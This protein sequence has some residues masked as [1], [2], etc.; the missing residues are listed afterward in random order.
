MPGEAASTSGGSGPRP[1]SRHGRITVSCRMRP[2][3]DS[4]AGQGIARAPWVLTENS[5]ALHDRPVGRNASLESR[6]APGSGGSVSAKT[7]SELRAL[8]HL[9]R[10]DSEIVMDAVFGE[11]ATT[12]EVYDK[13]FKWIVGGTAEGLNG[14]ILAYGQTCSGKTYSISGASASRA[15]D[16]ETGTPAV[17]AAKGIIHF[18]LEDL[19]SSLEAKASGNS[20]CECLVRMSYCELYMERVNDLLRK[21]SPQ[22]QHLPVKEDAENRGTFYVEGL[23]E[24]IVSSSEEVISILATAEKRRR[25]AHTKYNE[26]SSRS[27]TLLTMCVECSAPL[28]EAEGAEALTGDEPRVTK[29]SRLILVDLAGNERVDAGTEYMAES[30]SINKSLF[31]LGKVIEKLSGRAR[32]ESEGGD[33]VEAARAEHV[34][35][36]DSKLTRL[37]SVHLGGNSQTGVLVTLTPVEDCIEQSLTTL[38][39]AQKAA[40]IRCVAKPTLVSKE[41][42]LIIKQR[43]IISQL[44]QQVR[45]LKEQQAQQPSA[46]HAPT[47]AT[48]A[49]DESDGG[50]SAERQQCVEHMQA[51]VV[52]TSSSSSAV[53]SQSREMDAIVTALHRNNDT[54]RKQKASILEEFRE[55][56]R[57]IVEVVREV[58]SSVAELAKTEKAWSAESIEDLIAAQPANRPSTS[59][60]SAWE[61]AVKD[62]R[63]QLKALLQ[64]AGSRLAAAQQEG[65]MASK[66]ASAVAFESA[67]QGE[68]LARKLRDA[69]DE[70]RTLQQ[71]N[72]R[73]REELAAAA[74]SRA[75]EAEAAMRQLREENSRLRTTMKFLAAER[76][77]PK[78][79]A[80]LE[81]AFKRSEASGGKSPSTLQRSALCFLSSDEVSGAPVQHMQT[82]TPSTRTS[83]RIRSGCGTR[84]HSCDRDLEPHGPLTNSPCRSSCGSTRSLGEFEPI[85]E[86]CAAPRLAS[87]PSAQAAGSSHAATRQSGSGL[88]GGVGSPKETAPSAV[89]SDAPRPPSGPGR[90]SLAPPRPPEAGRGGASELAPRLAR[91]YF[92]QLGVRTSWK[93]GDCAYWRGQACK[94]VKAM[95]DDQPLYV[96][97]RTPDGSEVTTDLCLLSEAPSNGGCTPATAY[98]TAESG[99]VAGPGPVRLAPLGDLFLDR[100]LALDRPPAIPNAAAPSF[101]PSVGGTVGGVGGSSGVGPGVSGR[102]ASL[103]A[104]GPSPL[105]LGSRQR[106]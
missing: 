63:M 87:P 28:E 75:N 35:I 71:E 20:G 54:L 69:E 32:I 80:E 25:V 102:S 57:A 14:A 53:V 104:R 65:E 40:T 83:S 51:L 91:D 6:D 52:G 98:P 39:F 12:R 24:K 58:T 95:P 61:P 89:A 37:L 46:T 84:A 8:D 66:A 85:I 67:A 101:V 74:N 49:K 55:L 70:G 42:S 38:R 22:S 59:G 94:V 41:Q 93:P 106:A 27:H 4:E 31:F 64:N 88:F 45:E 9:R 2:L 76:E 97:V 77:K 43:E 11:S 90:S 33:S 56:H 60:S 100:P 105:R 10:D 78:P 81:P 26:V 29:V 48:A 34:P 19:F 68:G 62:L 5:I 103:P 86:R 44:H 3:L 82:P 36:R 15:A 17:P 30:S 79:V 13:S 1:Q 16:D 99:G 73:L 23:K 47:G 21:I 7:R 92:R 18:A 50:L 96:V 72:A